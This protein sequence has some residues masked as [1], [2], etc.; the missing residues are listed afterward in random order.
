MDM[1]I[2]EKD[3]NK[4]KFVIEKVNPAFANALR[5]VLLS[6]IPKMAIEDVEFHLGSIRDEDGKEYES[7]SPLFDEIVAHRLGMLPIPTDISLYTSQD[8]CDCGGEGC[9]NCTIMYTLNKKG[10][11][12]VY[13]GDLEPLGDATLSIKEDLIPIVKLSKRQALLIYA[14]AILGTG[15]QHA[16]WQVVTSCGYKY[17]PTVE[18]NKEECDLCGLCASACPKNILIYENGKLKVDKGKVIDC[19]ICN[20]C[21]EACRQGTRESESKDLTPITIK[22]DDTKFVFSFETDGAITAKNTL[23][24]ALEMLEDKFTEFRDKISDLE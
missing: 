17:H 4:L 10:P 3:E 11:C 22:G 20:A 2:L 24:K 21:V 5:R 8:I 16:K 12:T 9:P 7:I 14:T 19:N 23:D 13:S 18:V 1:K 15:V 6:D